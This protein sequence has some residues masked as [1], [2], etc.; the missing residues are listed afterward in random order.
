MDAELRETVRQL[1]ISNKW[2][3]YACLS[4]LAPAVVV[5]LGAK[6][7]GMIQQQWADFL[8]VQGFVLGFV[9]LVTAVLSTCD[10]V[11]NWTRGSGF[12]FAAGCLVLYGCYAMWHMPVQD[13][14]LRQV[15]PTACV[16]P[17]LICFVVGWCRR[18]VPVS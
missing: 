9:L 11:A 15:I 3:F 10:W 16:V 2:F 12:W 4:F 17:G 6:V 7:P 18:F 5:A 8:R 14:K 13:I 1:R